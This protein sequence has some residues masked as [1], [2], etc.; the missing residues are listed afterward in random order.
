MKNYY[1][2]NETD[3]TLAPIGEVSKLM[4][5]CGQSVKMDYSPNGSSASALSEVFVDYFRYSPGARKLFRFDYSYSQWESCILYEL[6]ANRPV[7]YGG[8]KHSGGH[9]FVCDGYDGNG[10]YHFNWGWRGN[11]DGYFSL[12]S[13]NPNASGIGSAIGNDGYIIGNEIIIGL[14]P[15]TISTNERNSVVQAKDIVANSTTYTRTSSS[16]PFVITIGCGYY[17]YHNPS[18]SKAKASPSL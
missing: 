13:L 14:E 9:A 11:G 2:D 18:R 16:A 6:R 8:K 3:L 17:N 12:T 10:Y 1:Y 4:R 5:Y 15:N 7:M